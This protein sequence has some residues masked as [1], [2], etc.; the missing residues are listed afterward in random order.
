[1][2]GAVFT[3]LHEQEL[4]RRFSGEVEAKGLRSWLGPM[5]ERAE[6]MSLPD[7]L[8]RG[9]WTPP[10]EMRVRP[11][12]RAVPPG[13]V[14]IKAGLGWAAEVDAA[15]ARTGAAHAE[16]LRVH[17]GPVPP[18]HEGVEPRDLAALVCHLSGLG[19]TAWKDL[20]ARAMSSP[21]RPQDLKAEA[22]LAAARL[23]AERALARATAAYASARAVVAKGPPVKDI[24]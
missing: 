2:T 7:G 13:F 4:R 21:A 23:R 5:L 22:R 14:P 1:M 20:Q 16:V 17:F 15:L 6:G 10:D 8:Y 3:G 12:P 11:S 18:L 19:P 24:S 9:G